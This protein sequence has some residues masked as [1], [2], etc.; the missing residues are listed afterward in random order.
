[1]TC[2]FDLHFLMAWLLLFSLVRG[3]CWRW[4]EYFTTDPWGI[5]CNLRAVLQAMLLWRFTRRTQWMRIVEY[6]FLSVLLCVVLHTQAAL[7][8][9]FIPIVK[10]LN[11]L[12]L[13][14]TSI[15]VRHTMGKK[16]KYSLT[17]LLHL[18]EKDSKRHASLSP[19][20]SQKGLIISWHNAP[21]IVLCNS[22]FTSSRV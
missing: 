2:S 4:S 3:P 10:W 6:T 5:S 8:E 1:M 18:T 20:E 19:M 11:L 7:A 13:L 15:P 9:N 22:H 17:E 21:G 16:P 14:Q 12:L